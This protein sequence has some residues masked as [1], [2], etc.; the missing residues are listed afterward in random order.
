V[1]RVEKCVWGRKFGSS[2]GGDAG[3]KKEEVVREGFIPSLVNGWTQHH[4]AIHGQR[5]SE[6]ML[7]R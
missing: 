2:R 5:A 6:R 3:K 1:A 7:K 4:R